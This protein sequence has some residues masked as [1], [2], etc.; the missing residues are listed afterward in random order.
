MKNGNRLTV[1]EA[2]LR[3]KIRADSTIVKKAID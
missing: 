3:W 1:H 2:F